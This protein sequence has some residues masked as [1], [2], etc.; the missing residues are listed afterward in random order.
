MKDNL[1]VVRPLHHSGQSISSM[2]EGTWATAGHQQTARPGPRARCTLSWD[3]NGRRPRGGIHTCGPRGPSRS[4][5]SGRTKV[6]IG[7]QAAEAGTLCLTLIKTQWLK[8]KWRVVEDCHIITNSVSFS[9]PWAHGIILPN[10][11]GTQVG[12]M[13]LPSDHWDVGRSRCTTS[14]LDNKNQPHALFL[15]PRDQGDP[16]FLVANTRQWR[17]N[18]QTLT[19]KK[20]DIYLYYVKLPSFVGC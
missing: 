15:F 7:E 4:L 6:C 8:P 18:G 19:W 17:F 12:V 16:K 2:S 20:N 13:W 14:E 10:F 9:S 5:A 1:C 11:P 3:L